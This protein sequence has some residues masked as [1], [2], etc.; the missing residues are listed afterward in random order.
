MIINNENNSA[1][2]YFHEKNKPNTIESIG[3]KKNINIKNISIEHKKLINRQ[4]SVMLIK[5]NLCFKNT[6]INS[7]SIN[8][9]TENNNNNKIII[10]EYKIPSSEYNNTEKYN[11]Y[12]YH[13]ISNDNSKKYFLKHYD[14]HAFIKK[15]NLITDYL[16]KQTNKKENSI[17]S[18]NC[19]I[20]NNNELKNVEFDKKIKLVKKKT[21]YNNI[22][23]K[24]I[25]DLNDN[26][27]PKIEKK[28]PQH[29]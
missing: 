16:D 12:I 11:K 1:K 17:N 10:Y 24:F 28:S 4:R 22:S 26:I 6:K 8:K 18:V 15:I 13:D 7:N 19:S 9:N 3:D 25:Y 2:E 21:S 20:N 27:N 23:K 29:N 5:H 14:S